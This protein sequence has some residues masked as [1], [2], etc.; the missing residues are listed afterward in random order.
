MDALRKHAH[1]VQTV[2]LFVAFFATG[3]IVG[4][5][6]TVSE[7]RPSFTIGDTDTAFEPLWEAFNLIQSR[8]VDAGTVEVPQLVDGAITGMI[9]S[10]GD[11]YST[12]MSPQH[13]A[14]FSNDLSGDIEGIGVVIRTNQETN[15]IEVV[16]VLEGAPARAAGVLPGDIFWEVDGVSTQGMTQDELARRVRGPA[17]TEVNIIFKR[18]DDFVELTITRARFSV[19][20]VESRI[21][22]GNIAYIKLSEFNQRA[23]QELDNAFEQLDINSRAGLIFDLRGNPGGLLGAAIDVGSLFIEEGVII[24]ETFADGSE[25]IFRAN[26]NYGNINV[27]LIVL[28]NEGSASASELVVGAIQDVVENATIIGET[29]FGKGTVQTIQPLSN[30]AALRLTIA[31]YLLPSR[32]WVHDVGV[33]PDIIV[34]WTPQSAEEYSSDF[35]DPQ[36]QAAIDLLL[37]Q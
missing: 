19:P 18:G 3:F 31:R 17:G 26:G 24:Y 1:K 15:L 29:T 22:D 7:A 36:L 16:N 32:T 13:Y 34:E 25:E 6:N 23:R 37:G 12:Y 28:V 5:M 35:I 27:P 8:Y 2:F 21:L 30:G 11:Q 20:N 14:M 4:N 10:L 33:T 9:N